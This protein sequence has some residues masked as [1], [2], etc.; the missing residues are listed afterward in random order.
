MP[1]LL[2]ALRLL[3]VPVFLWLVLGPEAD[4]WAVALLVVSG[5][6]DWLDGFLARQPL[7]SRDPVKAAEGLRKALIASA[8]A[9][10]QLLK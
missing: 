5:I 8:Y 1:N 4:G 3:G 9:T 10:A 7:F 6:T 2:S